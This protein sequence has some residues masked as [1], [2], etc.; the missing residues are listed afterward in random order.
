MQPTIFE[1]QN[2]NFGR[3]HGPV[4][5]FFSAYLVAIL[6]PEGQDNSLNPTLKDINW[7]NTITNERR[8]YRDNLPQ[9][10]NFELKSHL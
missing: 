3:R 10:T 7:Q 2:H 4:K 6:L 5:V 1:H 9:Q 8:A